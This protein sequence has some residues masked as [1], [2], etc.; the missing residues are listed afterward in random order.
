MSATLSCNLIEDHIKTTLEADGVLGGSGDLKITTFEA[1]RRGSVE[2]YLS[3]EMPACAIEVEMGGEE[4]EGVPPGFEHSF[5]ANVFLI[6]EAGAATRRREKTKNISGEIAR[7]LR[8]QIT[9]TDNLS[10]LPAAI[11]GGAAGSVMISGVSTVILEDETDHGYR[12][13]GL[14]ACV[15]SVETNL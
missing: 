7:V 8:K 4:K 1:E 10:D 3:N 13:V 6:C 15:V 9:A 5:I 11:T 2:E 14:V 12:A